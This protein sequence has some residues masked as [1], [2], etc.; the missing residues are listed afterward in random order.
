MFNKNFA[1]RFVKNAGIVSFFGFAAMGLVACGDDSSS[2]PAAPDQGKD[3][4]AP[5][6]DVVVKDDPVEIGKSTCKIVQDNEDVFEMK[7]E[8]NIDIMT[9]IVDMSGEKTEQ[10]SIVEAKDHELSKDDVQCTGDDCV[11]EGN[12]ATSKKVLTEEETEKRL[13]AMKKRCADIQ[14]ADKD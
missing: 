9:F 13:T 7:I 11:I 2:S 10:T 1:N 3:D 6:E 8:N 12:K 4:A 5:V 14:A